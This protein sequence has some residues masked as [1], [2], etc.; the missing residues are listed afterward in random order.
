MKTKEELNALKNEVEALN[1]K[2]SE[3]NNEEL[4][5]V[6]GGSISTYD[7]MWIASSARGNSG[8]FDDLD[9]FLG[10]RTAGRSGIGPEAYD[11]SGLV[12]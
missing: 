1:T 5:Q 3:L 10:W 2:L 6:I 8:S 9:D 12:D 11:C 4:E 7:T